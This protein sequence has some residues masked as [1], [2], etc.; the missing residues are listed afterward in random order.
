MIQPKNPKDLDAARTD[1]VASACG[2]RTG[3]LTPL[4]P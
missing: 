2:S 1:P 3:M 4:L